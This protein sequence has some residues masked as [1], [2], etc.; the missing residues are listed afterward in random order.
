MSFPPWIE[1]Y[2]TTKQF[3]DA[4][5][6]V[7]E[8]KKILG[9]LQQ[10]KSPEALVAKEEAT[11]ANIAG[12]L[13]KLEGNVVAVQADLFR[14]DA[15][16]K[17]LVANRLE[18]SRAV[19]ELRTAYPNETRKQIT[20]LVDPI[21]IRKDL[22]DL[23]NSVTK[24]NNEIVK[25]RGQMVTANGNL[26]RD[27]A[28]TVFPGLQNADNRLRDLE[29]S[30]ARLATRERE[31]RSAMVQLTRAVSLAHPNLSRFRNTL[32]DITNDLIR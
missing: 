17:D 22:K 7:V 24:A 6:N 19:R 5:N 12:N 14:V 32:S 16:F 27:I 31:L 1:S 26:R 20:D 4:V 10:A 28:R 9:F 2:V 8:P 13:L 30:S 11:G 3:R 23:E 29:Q 25:L 15:V 18:T 21:R